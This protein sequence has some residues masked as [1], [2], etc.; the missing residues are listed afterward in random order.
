MGHG[1][2]PV[3]ISG[4]AGFPTEA[5]LYKSSSGYGQ[6]KVVLLNPD[7]DRMAKWLVTAC[8]DAGAPNLRVCA[9]RVALR[10]KCQ[11]GNQFPV[12]GFVDEGALYLFRDGVTVGITGVKDAEH[13]TDWLY[14]SP[15]SDEETLA[16]TSG[17]VA[18]VYSFGRVQGTKRAD[19]ASFTGKPASDYDGLAWQAAIREE[20]Q[21][22]WTSD[23]N[24]LMSAWA[25]ANVAILKDT[26][27]FD[28]F[29]QQAGCPDGLKWTR[30]F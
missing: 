16:L 8:A 21:A 20:Y 27:T 19:F 10:V 5:C 4:W 11:S 9:E 6:I 12:A 17:T 15:T 24:R 29:F 23:Q 1:C 14:R 30:W 3:E 7:N 28:T 2:A 22:A 25:K 13:R 26:V 18:K